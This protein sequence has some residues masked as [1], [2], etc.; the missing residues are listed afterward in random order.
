MAPE[1]PEIM[2]AKYLVELGDLAGLQV[3]VRDEISQIGK[4]CVCVSEDLY[5]CL[6]ETTSSNSEV[7]IRGVLRAPKSNGPDRS[8]SIFGLWAGPIGKTDEVI[9]AF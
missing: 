2:A 1:I 9:C 5:S 4:F 3:F 7:A 8:A 6:F